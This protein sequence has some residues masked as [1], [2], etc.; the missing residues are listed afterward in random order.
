MVGKKVFIYGLVC[1]VENRV[2]YVGKTVNV[3]KRFKTHVSGSS[4][5]SVKTWV[6]YL[7]TEGLRPE[8]KILDECD[9]SEWE[10]REKHWIST[11]GLSN[12][13]NKHEGGEFVPPGKR[14]ARKKGRKKILQI[15]KT[16]FV[17][18]SETKQLI[19]YVSVSK[20]LTNKR[21]NIRKGVVPKKHRDA[22][23]ELEHFVEYWM[24]KYS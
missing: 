21:D 6:E 14:I 19:N 15:R 22:V 20:Y 3:E 13:L 12:L 5:T 18:S 16:P 9:L 23:A 8:V 4:S 17:A 11:F 2:M 10:N 24:K 7:K 1:P